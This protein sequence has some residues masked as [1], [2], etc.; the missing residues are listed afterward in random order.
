MATEEILDSAISSSS[1]DDHGLTH[2]YV[3]ARLNSAKAWCASLTDPE[4]Y[5]QVIT[6]L[7]FQNSE[8]LIQNLYYSFK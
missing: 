3:N 1:V 8:L 7:K 4:K 5:I 2:H 6:I